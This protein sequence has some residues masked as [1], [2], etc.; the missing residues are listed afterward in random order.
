MP[1]PGPRITFKQSKPG[2]STPSAN[3]HQTPKPLPKLHLP[4]F[5][6]SPASQPPKTPATPSTPSTP[7][8]GGGL[9]LKLKFGQK[10]K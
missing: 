4:A 8:G 9:K 6:A 5:S 3:A 2:P 1:P 10:P 7:S